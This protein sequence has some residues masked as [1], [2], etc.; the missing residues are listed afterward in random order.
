MPDH[1]SEFVAKLKGKE[2][3][4]VLKYAYVYTRNGSLRD[5]IKAIIYEKPPAGVGAKTREKIIKSF[6]EE[7]MNNAVEH[8]MNTLNELEQLIIEWA[9]ARKIIPNATTESQLLKAV[10][11]MGELADAVNKRRRDEMIDAIGDVIVCLI[12]MCALE[13][14]SI[15]QCL[16]AAWEQIKDRKGTLLPNGV[17]VKEGDQ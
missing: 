17:F 10:S 11:E 1:I 13:G 5:L 2:R 8:K 7:Y 6:C 16:Q 9:K 12:N 4:A 3:K 15:N 14:I